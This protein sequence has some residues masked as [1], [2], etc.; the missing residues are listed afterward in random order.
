MDDLHRSEDI[1]ADRYRIVRP[2]GHGGTSVTYEAEDLTN[3]RLVAIKVLSLRQMGD[4]KVLELFERESRILQQLSHPAIPKYLDY[5]YLDSQSDRRFYLVQELVSG[6]SLY[7]LGQ[8]G[9]KPT[10]SSVKAIAEQ[11]LEILDYLH[12]RVPPVIHR[13]IKP[14]NLIRQSD[15]RIFLVDFG[16]VQDVYRYTVSKGGTF[17]GTLGY[18]PPEQ[19]RG[20]TH[21]ASD[22]YALGA[23]LVY[24]LT[25]KSPDELPQKR[26]KIDFRSTTNLSPQ[27][28]DWLDS[29]LEPAIEDRYQSAAI[30]LANLRSQQ[31]IHKVNK[32]GI[33]HSNRV[34]IEKQKDCLF[35]EFYS[36]SWKLM[37]VIFS[38]PIFFLILLVLYVWGSFLIMIAHAF[39][40]EAITL[41]SAIIWISIIITLSSSLCFWIVIK[42][43]ENVRGDRVIL[44]IN[45]QDFT[46]S[47]NGFL[48]SYICYGKTKN[49]IQLTGS[50]KN[51]EPLKKPEGLANFNL[52]SSQIRY[53]F[54]A[55]ITIREMHW[56][57][58][59]LSKFLESIS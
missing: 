7:E 46:L 36:H 18:M 16:A 39:Q 44:N 19:F 47:I 29:L 11:V 43:I 4:W 24:L 41:I 55:I 52:A 51:F 38:A 48:K 54:K 5:F 56:V 14:Q 22:V 30:A 31:G 57:E 35:I 53:Q 33:L 15:G 45:Q 59:E 32:G 21:C 27:F 10:E 20:E 50:W 34:A 49:L 1:I 42:H 40:Y 28:A 13:D 23:T 3:Y 12:R 17:V 2:L 8:K 25:G 9:W 26:L 37:S 58:G 6:R